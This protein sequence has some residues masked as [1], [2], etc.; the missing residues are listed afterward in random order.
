MLRRWRWLRGYFCRLQ[1]CHL[2]HTGFSRPPE[3]T[4]GVNRMPSEAQALQEQLAALQEANDALYRQHANEKAQM[5]LAIEQEKVR[6]AELEALVA[7]YSE[8]NEQ[9][10]ASYGQLESD[11]YEA[12]ERLEAQ[13][14][15]LEDKIAMLEESVKGFTSELVNDLEELE[16][17][18]S[19]RESSEE[20]VLELQKQV[21]ER[22]ERF[23]QLSSE[24]DGLSAALQQLQ[25]AHSDLQTSF[26]DLQADKVKMK[27]T[28]EK[29]VERFEGE[30]A[31][32]EAKVGAHAA[33]DEV[34]QVNQSAH[35][36]R[37]EQQV[38]AKDGEI[39]QLQQR[40]KALENELS[41]IALAGSG[42]G[43]AGS[44]DLAVAVR[45]L[46]Q[47]V[48]AKSEQLVQQ[49]EKNLALVQANEQI[50]QQFQV[51]QEEVKEVRLVLLRGI[52]GDQGVD[53]ELYKH[54]RLS[55]LLRLRIKALEH[56][57]ILTGNDSTT[58]GKGSET[59]DDVAGEGGASEED[60][61]SCHLRNV[62]SF[63]AIDGLGSIGKLE[64]ELRLVR[65]RNKRLQERTQRL[66]QELE[67]AHASLKDLQA[68]K[69]K[70]VDL[71]GR[72]RVEKELRA[73]SEIN[74]KEYAEK[75]AVLSEHIE[76]LMV[77]LKHEAAAKTKAIDTQR[78]T[79]K[80]LSETRDKLAVM[81]KKSGAKE[82]QIQ[83]LEQGARILEDQLRLMDEK[84][85][86]V[87]NKLDWT[88]A[89]SQKETKKLNNELS[90]LRMKWQLATDAGVLSL[91]PDW[92]SAKLSKPTPG[93]KP[94]GV[95]N[96][97]PRL[98]NNPLGSS[99]GELSPVS[100]PGALSPPPMSPP[101]MDD[102]LVFGGKRT[103]FEIPKLPQPEADVGTPWSDAK[104][105][106]LQRNL[107][108]KQRL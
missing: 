27:S 65:S 48:F 8:E 29:V 6:V 46:Q 83:E 4:V 94:L 37:A 45:E 75:I 99:R 78:R 70:V 1:S 97:E 88:R 35:L 62:E 87:R 85:I 96:S 28:H 92:A 16:K 73:K 74:C 2:A 7:A 11:K 44:T 81:S 95:S 54:V 24:Y 17:E 60:S 39:R 51:L 100:R 106:A 66:E 9:W 50:R 104:L 42:K 34:K 77:H 20:L 58:S 72:E 15:E 93:K 3:S 89:T 103:R 19:T 64:R 38:E 71:V 108:H 43:G 5:Q 105:A 98:G 107:Q 90:S 57:W 86:D 101:P 91:L 36:R 68:M 33:D 30:I 40:V 49:G 25:T 21:S 53:I 23:A 80:E 41:V 47:Q 14:R 84:F 22:D 61:A 10:R 79:E 63:S 18:K 102:S 82:Q 59:I 76:K 31:A 13:K 69:E 55:E 26:S 67:A 56:E 32:L 52:A 12:E